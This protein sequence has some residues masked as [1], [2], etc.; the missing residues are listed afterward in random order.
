[1]KK[2][3]VEGKSGSE[4]KIRAGTFLQNSIEIVERETSQQLSLM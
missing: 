1:M 3:S 4:K 2:E